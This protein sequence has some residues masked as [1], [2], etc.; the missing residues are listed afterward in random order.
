MIEKTQKIKNNKWVKISFSKKDIEK[1]IKTLW[2]FT[3]IQNPT[4]LD[5]SNFYKNIF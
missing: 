2:A 3:G 1:I 4:H 5:H